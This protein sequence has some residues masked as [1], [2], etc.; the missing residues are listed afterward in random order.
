MRSAESRKVNVLEMK[1]LIGLVGV[2][3]M[4]RVRNEVVRRGTGI[5]SDLA[6]RMDQRVQDGWREWMR[7][8]RLEDY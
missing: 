3:R 5:K 4:V 1:C 6:S 2:L 8:V 7:T